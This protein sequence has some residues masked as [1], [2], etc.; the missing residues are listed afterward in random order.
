ML[1]SHCPQDLQN[2]HKTNTK[3]FSSFQ[4]ALESGTGISSI[5]VEPP[6]S[7]NPPQLQSTRGISSEPHILKGGHTA[8][9]GVNAQFWD[10]PM[11]WDAPQVR[12]PGLASSHGIGSPS[13]IS[14]PGF[15]S[16][17]VS[18]EMLAHRALRPWVFC[19]VGDS[20]RC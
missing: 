6:P 12:A 10:S 20:H 2:K 8:C 5:L 18:L 19:Q 7:L 11:F 16:W 14:C 13:T 3:H 4:T 9:S 1:T 17:E 15:S